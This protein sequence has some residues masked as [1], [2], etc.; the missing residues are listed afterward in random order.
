LINISFIVILQIF[1]GQDNLL[2]ILKV[3]VMVHACNPSTV[4]TETGYQSGSSRPAGPHR[5][6]LSQKKKKK[7][8]KEKEK[9]NKN[10]IKV[11]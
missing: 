10:K 11:S 2:S 7:K 3:G 6:T 8:K 1:P 5:E 4:E 9:R